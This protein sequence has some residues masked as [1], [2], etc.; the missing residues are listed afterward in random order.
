[1]CTTCTHQGDIAYTE[2]K[3]TISQPKIS[4]QFYEDVIEGAERHHTVRAARPQ[5][6]SRAQPQEDRLV[7]E[8]EEQGVRQ[9]EK[10][11]LQ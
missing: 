7:E 2:E 3:G 10:P 11:G 4:S 9:G 6:H 8:G 5:D 1:M